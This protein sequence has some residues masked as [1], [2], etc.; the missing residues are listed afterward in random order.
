MKAILWSVFG[1]VTFVTLLFVV[2]LNTASDE[3]PRFDKYKTY[4]G[5]LNIDDW[6]I[7]EDTAQSFASSNCESLSL[8]D[9]PAISFKNEDHVKSSDAVLAAYCPSS[10]RP[11]LAGVLIDY[12]EYTDTALYINTTLRVD[13][14]SQQ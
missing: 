9:M 3:S 8:G 14:A 11:F 7:S 5:Q 6:T 4:A 13:T 10:Y 12:P 1:L 2:L